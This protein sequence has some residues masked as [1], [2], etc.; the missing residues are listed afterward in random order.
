VDYT[1]QDVAY[2]RRLIG[3]D[4]DDDRQTFSDTDISDTITRETSLKYA[5]ASL[6]E[7]WAVSQVLISRKIRTQDL[8]T[9]GPAVSAELRAL[10]DRLRAQADQADDD[11]QDAVFVEPYVPHCDR[12]YAAE[13]TEPQAWTAGMG[14]PW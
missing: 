5:A 14:W 10:A 7:Q 2:V 9:D 6:L 3:D 13:L 1:N 8:S 12:P 11:S 4:Y